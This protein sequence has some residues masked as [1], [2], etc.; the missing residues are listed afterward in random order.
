MFI[1]VTV[2]PKVILLQEIAL[3]QVYFF[4]VCNPSVVR[5]FMILVSTSKK[6]LYRNVCGFGAKD[7]HNILLLYELFKVTSETPRLYLPGNFEYC[8]RVPSM[9]YI[10]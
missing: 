3:Q 2:V 9:R 8:A 4:I 10:V 5:T 7:N 6:P 1:L